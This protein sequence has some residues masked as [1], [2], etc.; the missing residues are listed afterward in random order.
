MVVWTWMHYTCNLL[1]YD[2]LF[3]RQLFSQVLV[4]SFCH[5]VL[6]KAATQN[7]GLN[8]V[9][10]QIYETKNYFTIFR[11]HTWNVI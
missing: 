11:T 1:E 10:T 2:C 8:F 6:L 7:F 3:E 5:I 4:S 9:F